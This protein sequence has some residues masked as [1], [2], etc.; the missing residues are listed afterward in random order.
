VAAPIAVGLA[1]ICEPLIV[2][3]L[4]RAGI[5]GGGELL[6]R[7]WMWITEVLIGLGAI[8]FVVAKTRERPTRIA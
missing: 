5:W 6:Q 1:F 3:L 7:D 2:L 4:V 8:A